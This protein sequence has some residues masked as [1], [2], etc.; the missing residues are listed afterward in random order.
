MISIDSFEDHS[1]VT[2]G[3]GKHRFPSR[4]PALSP[5]PPMVVPPRCGVRVGYRQVYAPNRPKGWFG[6]S[7]FM[8]IK[9]ARI[10]CVLVVREIRKSNHKDR[11]DLKI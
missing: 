9:F 3:A 8:D 11:R 10:L 2:I 1:L 5:Q 6:A 7:S 4:T